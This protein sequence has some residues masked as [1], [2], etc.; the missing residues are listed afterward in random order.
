MESDG[1]LCFG[2]QWNVEKERR[3]WG[4]IGEYQRLNRWLVNL[5]LLLMMQ[6]W[7]QTGGFESL[8]RGLGLL[9]DKFGFGLLEVLMDSCFRGK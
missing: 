7:C 6:V 3:I 1:G 8:W 2:G 4:L 9:Q 5:G